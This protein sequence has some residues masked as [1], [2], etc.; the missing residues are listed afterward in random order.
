MQSAWCKWS[1]HFHLL[2]HEEKAQFAHRSDPSLQPS[3]E[4]LGCYVGVATCQPKSDTR[5]SDALLCLGRIASLPRNLW[6]RLADINTFALSKVNYGLVAGLPPPV[7]LHE[8]DTKIWK[9]VGRT[10]YGVKPLRS[11][12]AG[13]TRLWGSTVIWRTLALSRRVKAE[14][15]PTSMPW[16]VRS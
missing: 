11:V 9:A 16:F 1:A 3:A 2:E 6:E 8:F 12:I 7:L 15:L 4:I 5:R 13:A 10:G 14:R